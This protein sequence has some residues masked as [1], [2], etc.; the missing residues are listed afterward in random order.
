MTL[1][2][3]RSRTKKIFFSKKNKVATII[4]SGA[5]F[6]GAHFWHEYHKDISIQQAKHVQHSIAATVSDIAVNIKPIVLPNE[7]DLIAL[8]VA[9]YRQDKSQLSQLLPNYQKT[10]LYPYLY[11][12]TISQK[13]ISEGIINNQIIDFFE[14]YNEL[15]VVQKL[16]AQ[17]M[18]SWAIHKNWQ[19]YNRFKAN[20]NIKLLKESSD[21]QCSEVLDRQAHNQAQ[22]TNTLMLA[23]SIKKISIV[24]GYALANIIQDQSENQRL[25]GQKIAE[26][27]ING[28]K[29]DINKIE[30]YFISRLNIKNHALMSPFFDALIRLKNDQLSMSELK[31]LH[32]NQGLND[33][34]YV[35]EIMH[36]T[37]SLKSSDLSDLS[38]ERIKQASESVFL[39]EGLGRS[40]ILKQDWQALLRVIKVMPKSLQD[41]NIWLYW[42]AYALQKTL[43]PILALDIWEKLSQDYDFYAEMARDQLELTDVKYQKNDFN[44][45]LKFEYDAD[46]LTK[47]HALQVILLLH[48]YGFWV[49]ASQEF[50]ALLIDATPEQ[51]ASAAHLAQNLG[52]IERQINYAEKGKIND[53]ALRYPIPYQSQVSAAAQEQGVDSSLI[54]AIMRQESRFERFAYSSVGAIGL[55]QIM[56]KTA[57]MLAD[58]QNGSTSINTATLMMP[59]LNIQLGTRY[60][61][62]LQSMGY[63]VAEVAAAYNAGPSRVKRWNSLNHGKPLVE[64][65]ELIPFEETRSYVKNVYAN[66]SAYERFVVVD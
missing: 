23:K 22:S 47:S 55:M 63:N 45:G 1:N 31:N 10:A 43:Q 62:Q 2:K 49:E 53:P 61:K 42:K 19:D 64:W 58:K 3:S 21:I 65:I 57:Q 6:V 60:L 29:D 20:V 12:R 39:M 27:T 13:Q 24:C 11:I 48:T 51:Y 46:Q 30:K 34:L 18:A 36:N 33:L 15:A 9:Y 17:Y 26:L 7:S 40:A 44:H 54:Y 5:A 8:Q 38:S 66:Q 14:N 35:V 52:I 25:I 59:S 41:K 28:R 32:L 16:L 50:N 56:P 37:Q 4:L